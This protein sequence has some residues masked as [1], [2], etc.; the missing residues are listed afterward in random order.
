M[1]VGAAGF[2]TW[3]MYGGLVLL[4]IGMVVLFARFAYL[5]S[6]L[7]LYP[8][9]TV[10]RRLRRVLPGQRGD[11]RSLAEE[12]SGRGPDQVGHDLP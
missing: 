12:P 8:T 2:T 9:A 10:L 11:E 6:F 7:L 5:V 4:I 1:E 3:I